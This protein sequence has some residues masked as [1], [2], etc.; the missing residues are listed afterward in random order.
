MRENYTTMIPD[1]SPVFDI[2]LF[3]I[4][5]RG[6]WDSYQCRNII[7][8]NTIWIQNNLYSICYDRI[9]VHIHVSYNYHHI[10]KKNSHP[11]KIYWHLSVAWSLYLKSHFVEVF[12]QL[13]EANTPGVGHSLG[14][15]GSKSLMRANAWHSQLLWMLHQWFRW[16]NPQ[17]MSI[18]LETWIFSSLTKDGNSYFMWQCGKI[19]CK[20]SIQWPILLRKY[21]NCRKVLRNKNIRTDPHCLKAVLDHQVGWKPPSWLVMLHLRCLILPQMINHEVQACLAEDCGIVRFVC[22][23]KQRNTEKSFLTCGVVM[24]GMCL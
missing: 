13:H 15:D 16:P 9:Y 8:W 19:S 7:T 22:L 1:E 23:W 21:H 18:D 20:R 6:R 3:E 12:G 11:N 4:S 10:I 17:W 24:W 2:C 5:F 14:T